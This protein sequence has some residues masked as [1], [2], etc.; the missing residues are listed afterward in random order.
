MKIINKEN[1][2]PFLLATLSAEAFLNGKAIF[3]S[4][5]SEMKWS[6]LMT[7]SPMALTM[8]LPSGLLTQF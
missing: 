6:A 7:D 1:R 4:E 5:Q 3:T 2:I 8:T